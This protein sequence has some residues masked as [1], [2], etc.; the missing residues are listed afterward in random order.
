[1]RRLSVSIPAFCRRR[2]ER[3]AGERVPR[4][5]VD[6]DV[7][8]VDNIDGEPAAIGSES[9]Y[10]AAELAAAVPSS[11]RDPSSGAAAVAVLP[12]QV[13]Q[14]ARRRHVEL[15][16][17]RGRVRRHTVERD[18]RR[19]RHFQPAEIEGHRKERLVVDVHQM[20]TRQIPAVVAPALNN[21]ARARRQR[22][23][24]EVSVVV[25]DWAATACKQD[26]LATG[27]HLWPPLADFALGGM[28]SS[29]L[30]VPPADDTR[31]EAR[32]RPA[33]G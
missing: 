22:L 31:S 14:R 11:P 3:Q 5:L 8:C 23:H 7:I 19:T 6:P 20:A 21:L 33:V 24:D 30:R 16:A 26:C 17:S 29:V 4:P 25:G 10:P 32:T 27:Q 1:M 2:V 12:R 13:H 15:G 18:H 9:G 28:T